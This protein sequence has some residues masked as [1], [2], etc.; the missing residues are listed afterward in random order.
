MK[1]KSTK[2]ESELQKFARKRN[3]AKALL[4]SMIG[5][6]QS[7][8]FHYLT[9]KELKTLWSALSDIYSVQMNWDDNYEKAKATYMN[10]NE[11]KEQDEN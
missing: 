11:T 6:L 10:N 8:V 2:P 1:R 4:T 5:N 7:Q 3:W 9:P